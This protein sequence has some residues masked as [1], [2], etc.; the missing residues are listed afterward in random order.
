MSVLHFAK[1]GSFLVKSLNV[2]DLNQE[3]LD[4]LVI[5]QFCV[6]ATVL[7]SR[8]CG[9]WKVP[10]FG[11]LNR[12]GALCLV[13]AGICR[14]AAH[15]IPGDEC[16][17]CNK[18]RASICHDGRRDKSTSRPSCVVGSRRANQHQDQHEHAGQSAVVV[19]VLLR[20]SVSWA[21]WTIVHCQNVWSDMVG[22]VIVLGRVRNGSAIAAAVDSDV[23]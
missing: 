7:E 16:K 20:L 10:E 12:V 3:F 6:N 14:P 5:K 17:E 22:N 4:M 9:P 11:F 18:R 13:T 15:S 21:R 1:L 8:K 23:M 2:V 19:C